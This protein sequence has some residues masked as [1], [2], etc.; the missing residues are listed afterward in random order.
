MDVSYDT[1]HTKQEI[2]LSQKTRRYTSEMTE[3]Q[4]KI[5]KPL[6]PLY[7]KGRGRPIELDMRQ[8]VNAIFC[9]ARTGCQWENLPTDYQNHNSVYYHY[10][11]WCMDGTWRQIN[12]AMRRQERQR[13]N[14]QPE[15]TA[16][17][18]D[19]QSVKTTETGGERGYDAGK[20]VNGRKRHI[21][22]D[23]VGNL[24]EVVVHAADVQ[25]RDGAKQVLEKLTDATNAR[26]QKIWADG[27]Y[28]GRL[29]DWVQEKLTIILEIVARDPNQKGFQ[30]LPRRWVVERTFAWLRR[31]RRLSKDY[32]KCLKSSEG[33][34]YIASIHTM[35][36]RL[37]AA[38]Q[39]SN[40]LLVF[41]VL[42]LNE[43]YWNLT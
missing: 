11:K 42:A 3:K 37:A 38:I 1:I 10:R 34:I 4:W 25:D 26:L 18:I 2:T 27:G 23:T 35:M 13:Q 12:E 17:I 39:Y 41:H 8:V 40:A 29:I 7:Q 15:P 19:S 16:G 31:Y 43:A 32:E 30:V 36:R 22:T 33:V 14:R 28:R 24:L 20:K 9:V 5:I 21:I 6:L